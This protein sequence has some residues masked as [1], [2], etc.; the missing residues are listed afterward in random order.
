MRD[1]VCVCVC[2][3]R[4]VYSVPDSLFVSFTPAA[5]PI[6]GL[7]VDSDG[8]WLIPVPAYDGVIVCSRTMPP[9]H[10]RVTSEHGL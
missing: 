10:N 5:R 6:G 4:H 2:M 1:D 7:T 8:R 9:G 3:F